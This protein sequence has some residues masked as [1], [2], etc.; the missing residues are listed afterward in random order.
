MLEALQIVVAI[1]GKS[2]IL[3]RLAMIVALLAVAAWEKL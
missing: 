2:Y 3:V 1:R